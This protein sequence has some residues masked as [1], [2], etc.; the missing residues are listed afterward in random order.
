GGTD[1]DPARYGAQPDPELLA[2]ESERDDLEL[3]LLECA[4]EREIPVLG[5]CRG[6]QLVNVHLGGTLNQHIP[7]HSRFDVSA[8]TE[9]HDVDIAPDSVLR[10]IYGERRRVNSLHHQTVADVGSGLRVT[11]TADDG[12]VEGLELGDN[13]VAVQWHPE[14]MTSRSTDPIFSWLVERASS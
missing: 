5:I 13:L 2:V 8:D 4:L 12:T 14:M 9:V 10:A 11:A 6:I 7:A 3:R 1:I